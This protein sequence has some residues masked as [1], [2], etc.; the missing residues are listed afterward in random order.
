MDDLPGTQRAEASGQALLLRG[1]LLAQLSA[2]IAQ[3]IAGL[4]SGLG[5][6]LPGL[7]PG[8]VSGAL[9]DFR[10]APRRAR[11]LCAGR[12]VRGLGINQGLW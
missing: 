3:H 2:G 9:A 12:G 10:R 1:C 5:G 8:H 4:G 7:L 6:D 11:C